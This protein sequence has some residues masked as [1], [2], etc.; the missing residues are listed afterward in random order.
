[1]SDQKELLPLRPQCRKI[2]I[3]YGSPAASLGPTKP[4][5]EK[6]PVPRRDREGDGSNPEGEASVLRVLARLWPWSPLQTKHPPS[7]HPDS[8]ALLPL[9]KWPCRQSWEMCPSAVTYCSLHSPVSSD[10]QLEMSGN[11]LMETQTKSFLN[12]IP[13]IMETVDS[14]G[15]N[16]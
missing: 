2:P 4:Q 8:P 7:A 3:Y 9:S 12:S 5:F 1:M 15:T 11:V 6:N 13:I 14:G 16:W 10:G